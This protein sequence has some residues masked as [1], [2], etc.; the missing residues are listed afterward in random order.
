[1]SAENLELVERFFEAW[2]ERDYDALELLVHDDMEFHG[3]VEQ[4]DRPR[5]TRS[6]EEYRRRTE[7]A[8]AELERFRLR[9]QEL[10]DAGDRVAVV[11][12]MTGT[13]K[14]SRVP[15][16]FTDAAVVTVV[17]GRVARVDV[18][19][20]RERALETAGLSE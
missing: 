11:F 14:R 18:C 2:N 19:G 8:D 7:L 17:D 20:T 6:L 15:I 12:E 4:A 9:P 10:V 16:G 13:G 5:V 3:L 1:M